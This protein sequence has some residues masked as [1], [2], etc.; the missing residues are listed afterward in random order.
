MFV[1]IDV[2]GKNPLF[3]AY[4]N[5]DFKEFSRLIEYTPTN[6]NCVNENGISLINTVL[7]NESN[8]QLNKDFFDKLLEANVCVGEIEKQTAPLALA[9]KKQQ[10]I[11]YMDALIKNNADVNLFFHSGHTLKDKNLKEIIINSWYKSPA[12]NK[13]IFLDMFT[14]IK[15]EYFTIP[16]IEAMKTNRID[17]IELI[18]NS[19]PNL[20]IT[21]EMGEPIL[22]FIL[23]DKSIKITPEILTLLIKK[24]I[25]PK[26]SNPINESAIHLLC[27]FENDVKLLNILMQ[28][29]INVNEQ[30]AN[31][32]T[33][34]MF[35]ASVSHTAIMNVLIKN[36]ADVNATNNDGETAIMKAAFHGMGYAMMV[37]AENNADLS[38]QDNLGNNV[39]H[40]ILK[41]CDWMDDRAKE[42]VEN[43]LDLLFVKNNIGETPMEQ[44]KKTLGRGIQ[45][46]LLKD[47]IEKRGM[48]GKSNDI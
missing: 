46:K 30:T 44:L 42:I 43:N 10:D 2:S 37:L 41:H 27:Y 29:N 6:V 24:G 48:A 28:E 14:E 34:L 13:N 47:E 7:S 36:G 20:K 40:Y 1:R 8:S 11:H 16:I 26:Q 19:N 38:I 31:G 35:A 12:K 33:A 5:N 45:Y 39:A 3:S 25:D 18:L 21:D 23:K 17:K 22:N 15:G 9:I 4:E 32:Y